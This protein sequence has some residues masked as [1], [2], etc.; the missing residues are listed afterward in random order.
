[1]EHWADRGYIAAMTEPANRARREENERLN[2]KLAY[3]ADQDHGW[4]DDD[5]NYE[6]RVHK[7]IVAY[8]EHGDL[9]SA[10]TDYQVDA[11]DIL[12]MLF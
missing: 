9:V 10:A 6:E 8:Y 1:V 11:A 12:P 2:V 4:Q 3:L 7:A 5:E